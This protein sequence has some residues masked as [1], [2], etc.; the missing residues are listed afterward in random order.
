MVNDG[1]K[2]NRPTKKIVRA[3]KCPTCGRRLFDGDQYSTVSPQ[4]EDDIEDTGNHNFMKCPRCK[5]I[6]SF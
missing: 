2:K 3:I 4:V 5:Q 1:F 6:I